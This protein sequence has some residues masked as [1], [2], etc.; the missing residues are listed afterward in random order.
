MRSRLIK[1]KAEQKFCFS[2]NLF[3]LHLFLT[4]A[5][6]I[7]FADIFFHN[8]FYQQTSV[9]MPFFGYPKPAI[10]CT[11]ITD[12][13]RWPQYCY[14]D[15]CDNVW[16]PVW[17]NQ[18]SFCSTPVDANLCISWDDQRF[19]VGMGKYN[20]RCNGCFQCT[21]TNVHGSATFSLSAYLEG[22]CLLNEL[23]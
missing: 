4:D 1:K 22:W 6:E 20:P 2:L 14:T 7:H 8:K 16:Y 13:K 17:Q 19:S 21:G 15:D 5:P 12:I 18:S 10:N 9:D 11:K 23:E 3:R